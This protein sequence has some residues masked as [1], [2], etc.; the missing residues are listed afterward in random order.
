MCEIMRPHVM[1]SPYALC[2]MNAQEGGLILIA[3][4][5][6]KPASADFGRPSTVRQY[7]NMIVL[8]DV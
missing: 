8:N 6:I 3:F 2:K 1:R 4:V 7:I 5:E